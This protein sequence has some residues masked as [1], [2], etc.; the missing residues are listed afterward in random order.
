MLLTCFPV[1][2]GSYS[3]LISASAAVVYHVMEARRTPGGVR[4]VPPSIAPM[5]HFNPEG[6]GVAVGLVH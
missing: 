1:Q 3:P 4:T 5:K 2:K 6:E